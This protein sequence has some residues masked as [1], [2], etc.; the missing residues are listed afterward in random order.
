MILTATR[1][2]SRKVYNGRWQAFIRWCRERN[3]NSVRTSVKHVLEFL[4]LKSEALAV[5]N[6]K[7][8]VTAISCR[9]VMVQ[10]NPL[11]L[12]PSIKR[13][14][15]GLRTHQWHSMYD[16]V[17]LVSRA[18]SDNSC[19]GTVRTH[20]DLSPQVPDLDLLAIISGC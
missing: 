17:Y 11:S 13:W 6:M 14:L 4:Q 3:Q 10:G 12:E 5:N 9:H 15:K 16:H 2:F 8:Y 7:D 18:G 19:P 1:D 20:S